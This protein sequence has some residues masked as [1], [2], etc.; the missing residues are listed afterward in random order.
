M[1]LAYRR[2]RDLLHRQLA[3][4][5]SSPSEP[6]RSRLCPEW[7]TSATGKAPR[8]RLGLLEAEK[9]RCFRHASA[10]ARD[11]VRHQSRAPMPSSRRRSAHRALYGESISKSAISLP[12]S[13]AKQERSNSPDQMTPMPARGEKCAC[14]RDCS[15]CS[16]RESGISTS[17]A[18]CDTASHIGDPGW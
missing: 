13:P 8:I 10:A 9:V 14:R 4:V 12:S 16:R 17:A 1:R 5:S 15:W 6:A 11:Y 18:R 3:Q 7:S 2:R